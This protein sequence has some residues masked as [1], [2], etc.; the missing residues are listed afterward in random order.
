M[1]TGV[2]TMLELQDVVVNESSTPKASRKWQGPLFVVGMW[3]SGTSLLYALL[4]K[5]PQI[6]LMYE[7]DLLLLRPLFWTVGGGARKM[8][9]WEFWNQAL[10]RHGLDA[11][12]VTNDESSLT[13]MAKKAYREYA[14]QKGALIGGDKSPNYF[15][16]MTRLAEDFPD[17]RFIV[18]WRD[19]ASICRSVIRAA[20]TAHSWFDR[21]GMTLRVLLGMEAMRSECNRLA[22]RGTP[23]FELQYDNL[24]KDPVE[25]ME[26]ICRFLE[27]PFVADMANLEGADRSAIYESAHHE[28]V[29]S[30]RI[31]SSVK[32]AEVL[33]PELKSKIERYVALWQGQ[34]GGQWPQIVTKA[35]DKAGKPSLL[36]RISDRVRYRWLRS[37]DAAIVLLYCFLPL[38]LL[39]RFREFQRRREDAR[40]KSRQANP[41]SPDSKVL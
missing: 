4:N 6:A 21:R 1:E 37:V 20:Q 16:S 27:I 9:R 5:H 11:V 13:S 32:R 31:V 19:P 40:A 3:R 38:W 28:L 25:T 15:D 26:S 23:V 36:E 41:P 18:I 39:S 24:V 7:G 14:Q 17:A 35:N 2:D 34:A 29:H 10:Q 12:E 30:Q 33:P 8:R 22:G